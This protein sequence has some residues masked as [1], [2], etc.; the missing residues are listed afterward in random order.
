MKKASSAKEKPEIVQPERIASAGGWKGGLGGI[1]PAL[2][3]NIASNFILGQKRSSLIFNL[4]DFIK[5]VSIFM[6]D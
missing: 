5:F 4:I 2:Q 6:K 1:P 3:K